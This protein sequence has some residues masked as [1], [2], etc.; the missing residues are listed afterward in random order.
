MRCVPLRAASSYLVDGLLGLRIAA[1][2]VFVCG[3]GARRILRFSQGNGFVHQI[4]H[5][6][7]KP[8][9]CDVVDRLTISS[10]GGRLSVFRC[11][12]ST[13]ICS[14]SKAFLQGSAAIGRTNKVCIFTSKGETLGKLIV[15]PFRRTP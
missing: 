14:C 4:N 8:K 5:R 2:C 1:S 12:K 9:R 11:K 10:D 3:K 15:G 6:K 7:G 13:L